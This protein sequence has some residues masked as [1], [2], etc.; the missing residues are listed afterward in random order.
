MKTPTTL[1]K[2]EIQSL[3]GRGALGVVYKGFDPVIKRP[4]AIKTIRK[5]LAE[6]P[7]QAASFMAR[8]RQEARAAGQLCH[9]NLVSVY[10]YWEDDNQAFISM[11]Y[12][13]GVSLRE[14]FRRQAAFSE[15]AIVSLAAQ[16]LDALAHAHERGVWHR[17]IKPGNLIVSTAGKLK[18][19]DFGVAR[20]ESSGLTKAGS[21]VGTLG[22]VAPEFFFRHAVD[23]RCDLFSA[24]AVLYELLTS[25]PAFQGEFEAIVYQVCYEQPLP[26][27][28]RALNPV[29]RKYDPI[30]ARA[31]AKLSAE[32]FQTAA[33]F[34]ALLAAAYASATEQTIQQVPLR[35]DEWR[36]IPSLD[37][38]PDPPRRLDP[39]VLNEMEQK[40]ATFIGPIAKFVVKH[41]ASETTEL[42]ALVARLAGELSDPTEK[43]AFLAQALTTEE[44]AGPGQTSAHLQRLTERGLIE[45]QVITAATQILSDAIGPIARI[46]TRRAA[47]R[48]RDRRNFFHLLTEHLDDEALRIQVTK[49]LER[50]K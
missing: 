50:I 19:A 4:V 40:L 26:A 30:V 5:D 7:E 8:F 24:G 48:A 23:H 38:E 45:L 44:P 16:L 34:K 27:S 22:Y 21:V 15:A 49:Q 13:E 31:L 46:V 42:R 12:V 18:V 20:V 37:I 9:P 41:A 36:T 14:C 47:A 35:P 29:W 17:D 33:E 3:L 2:Y 11:E 6:T 10:E 1:G 25:S 28:E 39:S 43:A 32:R